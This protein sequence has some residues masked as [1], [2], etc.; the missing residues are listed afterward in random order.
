MTIR[1]N[2]IYSILYLYYFFIITH[3]VAFQELPFKYESCKCLLCLLL[4]SP[5]SNE[6][7]HLTL[8]IVVPVPPQ[9]FGLRGD[10]QDGFHLLNDSIPFHRWTV[11]HC[12]RLCVIHMTCHQTCGVFP[13]YTCGSLTFFHFN[14]KGFVPSTSMYHSLGIHDDPSQQMIEPYP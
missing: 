3:H 5:T 14:S 7:N 11:D 1:T 6:K 2:S 8:M 12:P 10:P 4:Q 13:F 9:A